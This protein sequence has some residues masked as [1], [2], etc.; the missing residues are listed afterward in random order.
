M[1]TIG[2]YFRGMSQQETNALRGKL[3]AIAAAHGYIAHAGQTAG[4]GNAAAL[5]AGIAAGEVALVMLPDEQRAWVVEF[6]ESA[7]AT[8][9]RPLVDA[10]TSIADALREASAR[11][12]D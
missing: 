11:E 8:A 12:A 4:E 2:L 9:S 7:A 10:L 3:N 5:L 6:L 1:S